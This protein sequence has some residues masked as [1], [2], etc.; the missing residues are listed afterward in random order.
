MFKRCCSRGHFCAHCWLNGPS[1]SSKGNEA[2]LWMKHPS[3]ITPL[4]FELSCCR[5]VANHTTSYTIEVSHLSGYERHTDSS[6][7]IWVRVHFS[8]CPSEAASNVQQTFQ[9]FLY[10]VYPSYLKHACRHTHTQTHTHAH[11]HTHTHHVY[12]GCFFLH[13]SR[14]HCAAGVWDAPL[15]RCLRR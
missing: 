4:E 3:D 13:P 12:G 15:C 14:H 9:H 8:Q 7:L 10:F 2:K 11:T 1:V 6:V 5:S